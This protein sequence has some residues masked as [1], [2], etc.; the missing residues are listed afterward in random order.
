MEHKC[1]AQ[2]LDGAWEGRWCTYLCVIDECIVLDI[3]DI[4]ILHLRALL[5]S[6]F[7][8]IDQR[9]PQKRNNHLKPSQQCA[10][11]TTQAHSQPNPPH[12]TATTSSTTRTGLPTHRRSHPSTSPGWWT[13][14]H[15]R[16]TILI[17]KR[18]LMPP[19]RSGLARCVFRPLSM[20]WENGVF[21]TLRFQ[22]ETIDIDVVILVLVAWRYAV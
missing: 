9:P 18:T 5:S 11:Q 12:M 10:L 13:P 14:T 6:C 2:S 22:G 20:F 8:P 19:V 7:H 15:I 3:H 4:A 21:G 17:S 16:L 1:P